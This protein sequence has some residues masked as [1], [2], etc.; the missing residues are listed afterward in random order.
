MLD[1]QGLVEDR[2]IDPVRKRFKKGIYH[3]AVLF[4][5]TDLQLFEIK[6]TVFSLHSLIIERMPYPRK[7]GLA[8][9]LFL[10]GGP[11]RNRTCNYPLGGDCLIH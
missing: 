1:Q 10:D 3:H 5:E 6:I 11:N 2:Q 9:F 4:T 8:S 7:K